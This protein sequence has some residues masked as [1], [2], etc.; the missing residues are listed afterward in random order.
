MHNAPIEY[1]KPPVEAKVKWASF[2][3][4]VGSVAAIAV[5]QAVDADHSLIE[6]LPDWLEAVVIP[7]IP[8][9]ISW[10]A[11]WRARHTPRPDLA[12]SQR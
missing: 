6:V 2:G 10:L 1:G 7:L 4:F 8:T 9:A 11:G 5:L 12:D 3:T